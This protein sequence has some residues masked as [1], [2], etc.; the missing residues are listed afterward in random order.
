[1]DSIKNR[2]AIIGIRIAVAIFWCLNSLTDS[3]ISKI[4]Q[5]RLRKGTN[6]KRNRRVLS[7]SFVWLNP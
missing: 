3:L 5:D 2:M 1:M 6:T 7:P 4:S